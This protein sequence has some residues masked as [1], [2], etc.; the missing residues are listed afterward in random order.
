M[1]VNF[2]FGALVL[3]II[4]ASTV[5]FLVGFLFEA[6]RIPSSRRTQKYEAG[7]PLHSKLKHA[8]GIIEVKGS[9]IVFKEPEIG[10]EHFS[11]PL[12]SVRRVSNGR[13][14]SAGK[15]D[16]LA[17][18]SRF[19]D[20]REYMLVEFEENGKWHTVR[21]SA[22]KFANVNESVLNNILKAR[23]QNKEVLV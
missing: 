21:L 17:K 18:A 5:F 6:R 3:Y 11:I 19:L 15:E 10:K 23:S 1:G 16:V 9:E 14:G 7:H 22:H 20:E 12:K 4:M 2:D 13:K 8:E